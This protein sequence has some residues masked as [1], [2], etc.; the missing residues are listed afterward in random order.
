MK[1]GVH[2]AVDLGKLCRD[3]ENCYKYLRM[4]L[5]MLLVM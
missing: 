4:H 5:V 2:N 3:V 1:Y